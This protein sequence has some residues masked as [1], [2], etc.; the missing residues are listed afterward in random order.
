MASREEILAAVRPCLAEAQLSDL[1]LEAIAHAAGVSR[2]TIYRHFPEGRRQLLDEA[3]AYEVGLFWQGLAD[4]VRGTPALVDR[5]VDGMM[6]ARERLSEDDLLRKLL[7]TEP[8]EL[9]AML[10]RADPLIHLGISMYLR[11]L[12]EREALAPGVSIDHAADYLT[13]LMLSYIGSPGM[14]DM[15]DRKTVRRLVEQQF[16]AGILEP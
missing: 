2:A 5:L 10:L 4:H 3:V 15:S 14:W 12:L 13:R 6:E 9:I 8:I 7:A 11:G 16:L 1:S